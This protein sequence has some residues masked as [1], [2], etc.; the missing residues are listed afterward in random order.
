MSSTPPWSTTKTNSN[1]TDYDYDAN[2][3]SLNVSA[4]APKKEHK[5]LSIVGGAALAGSAAGMF[6]AGPFIALV[7]G[8]TAATV[9][10]QDT[11]AGDAARSVGDTLLTGCD[12]ARDINEKHQVSTKARS[13]M[14]SFWSKAKEVDEK[15]HIVE[16]TKEGA[17]EVYQKAKE[18]DEKHG[19]VERTNQG[20][21]NSFQF[22]S[23]KIRITGKQ[24]SSNHSSTFFKRKP[25][26]NYTPWPDRN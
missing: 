18:V 21:K 3:T 5:K 14:G 10:T 26:C 17:K 9:A 22:V 4:P 7:G 11:K 15:H 12:T 23:D 24:Q 1:A 19:I 8:I 25:D 6:I 20:L 16:N 13:G 2:T